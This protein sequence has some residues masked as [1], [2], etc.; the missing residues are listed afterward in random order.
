MSAAA[1][2]RVSVPPTGIA[3]R[4]WPQ[5]ERFPKFL[6]K[7][8]ELIVK[9]YDWSS[10]VRR[11]DMPVMLMYADHDAISTSH[12]AEFFNLLGGG[13]KDPGWENSQLTEARLAIIPGYSHY[14]FF[15]APEL[16]PVINKFLADEA[17]TKPKG[18]AAEASK[19]TEQK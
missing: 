5:P 18:A 4:D 7:L 6:D 19:A 2:R 8:G 15:T 1:D 9:D 17:L 16:G 10:E 13:V 14:N 12:M 3:S 11:L